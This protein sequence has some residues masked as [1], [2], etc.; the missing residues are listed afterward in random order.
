MT[1]VGPS[2]VL[3]KPLNSTGRGIILRSNYGHEIDD[4]RIMG[5]DHYI[6]AR[7]SH[8]ILLGDLERNLVSEIMWP[9]SGR[10]E[11]FYFDNANVC[12]IFNVG[13]LSIVEYGENEI[14]GSVRTEFMNP[15]LISV[16]L[17]ERRPVNGGDD[18]KKLAYLLDLKT[19]CIIDLV[20]GVTLAHV[21]HD[22]K[23]DWLELNETGH[24]LLFRDK[25]QRLM[26]LDP[27]TGRKEAILTNCTFVQ[28]SK[29]VRIGNRGFC[30]YIGK[31][32]C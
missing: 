22:A 3:V 16:R 17:N 8:T 12:L 29:E 24:K 27:R 19:I 2:Q 32:R 4:V 7:T 25:K 11:K 5:R 13:E 31:F 14:L 10:N 6:V 28:V 23:V 15:H 20:Y 18:N 26:L 30:F 9:N 21:S 1:Y